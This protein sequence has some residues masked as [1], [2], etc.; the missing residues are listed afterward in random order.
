MNI[1]NAIQSISGPSGFAPMSSSTQS[2]P[3]NKIEAQ[4]LLNMFKQG[5]QKAYSNIPYFYQIQIYIH[6]LISRL[7]T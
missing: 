6:H 2:K 3:S 1:T 7:L 5:N 4:A